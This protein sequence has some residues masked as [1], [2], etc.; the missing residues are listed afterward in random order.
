MEYKEF[1]IKKKNG[2]F[3][4]IC[5]PDK[6]LYKSQRFELKTISKFLDKK[7]KEN[8]LDNVFH[9]FI[10]G[11]NCV[12]AAE[13]HIG[14]Q[15][16]IMLDISDFF[17]SVNKSLLSKLYTETFHES[18]FHKDG[19]TAQG[20]ATSPCLANLAILPA[21]K[22]IK[23]NLPEGSVITIYADDI[24]ISTND[25]TKIKSIISIVKTQLQKYNFILNTKKTRVKNINQGFKRIL[26]INVGKDSLRATR[27]TMRKIRAARHQNNRHSLGGLINWSKCHK[28]KELK[29][30]I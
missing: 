22:S 21:I 7:L 2:T 17:D 30:N 14:Y 5:A 11:K 24:Q 1:K 25:K 18:L 13:Q 15:Y 23:S 8:N 26:G 12:T 6:S 3:R 20:F 28:P 4:R 10:K 19:R 16:T 9:G 27:K 29:C